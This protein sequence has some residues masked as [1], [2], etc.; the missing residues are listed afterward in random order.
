MKIKIRLYLFFFLIVL[1]NGCSEKQPKEIKKIV[2]LGD[3]L[4]SG[5]GL[6]SEKHL[7]KILQKDLNLSGYKITIINKSVSG[8]T[9]SDGLARLDKILEIKDTDLIILGLGANDMLQGVAPQK[10]K[11]N[12]QEI[13]TNI[14]NE[15]I[16]ILLTGMRATTSRG[17]SYK[18]K[19]DKIYPELSKNNDIFF[20]P[21]LLKDVALN[22]DFNQSD[23]IHPNFNGVKIIS[24]NLKKSIVE[25]IK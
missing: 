5:Y 11:K 15:N 21:F 24:I 23:G 10:T 2:L 3:S 18:K 12:L 22:P 9:S 14:K 17:L 6:S 4:M 8:D 16:E 7:D 19:F 25:L 1:F 20:F 13:I